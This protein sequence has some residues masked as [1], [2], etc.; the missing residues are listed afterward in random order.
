MSEVLAGRVAGGVEDL[1]AS[2]LLRA[3]RT[4]REI[5]HAEAA[6]QLVLA[7]AWAD[8]HPSESIHDAASFTVSGWEHEEPIAGEGAP[9]VAEFCVAELGGVLGMSSTGAKRL[10]GRVGAASPPAPAVGAGP[11][12][13]GPG[14]EGPSSRRD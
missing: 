12:R 7:A 14:L 3:I 9:L 11:R 5:E 4:S 1:T 6:R 13:P 8:L 2:D 10:I